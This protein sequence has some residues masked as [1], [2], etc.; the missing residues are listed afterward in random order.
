M[1]NRRPRTY[2]PKDGEK[3]QIFVK[4]PALKDGSWT[5]EAYANDRQ[6]LEARLKTARDAK[7]RGWEVDYVILPA[8]YW[9]R[10]DPTRKSDRDLKPI[11][12][13]LTN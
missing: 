5:H 13:T 10:E 2:K 3:F 12:S 1:L 4:P 7:G 6:Q 8:M 11:F 9:P